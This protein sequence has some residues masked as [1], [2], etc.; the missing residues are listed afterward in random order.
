[1]KPIIVISVILLGLLSSASV[2]SVANVSGAVLT[3]WTHTYG[4]PSNDWAECVIRTSDGGYALAGCTT[5]YGAGS[6]DA[7][8]VKI[9]ASGNSLWNKTYGG[10]DADFWTCV[11]QTNDGGYALGGY[12]A[13]FGLTKYQFWLLKTDS[14]G[15]EQW[16]QKYGGGDVDLANSMI[17]TSDGGYA[18]AGYRFAG[19]N[20]VQLLKTDSAGN[21]EWIRQYFVGGNHDAAYSVIQTSD[22]GY[23]MAGGT[24]PVGVEEGQAFLIKTDS[25][26]NMEWSGTYGG[27][28]EDRGYSVIQTG[29]GGCMLAG[30]TSSYAANGRDVWIVKTNSTGNMLWN[31]TYG[32]ADV[33]RGYSV[34]QTSDGGYALAGYTTSFGAGGTDVYL[35]KT[36]ESGVVPEFPSMLLLPVLV[37]L[38]AV[39]AVLSRK[40]P[41]STIKR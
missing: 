5:S 36:D 34:V 28:S 7:W 39:V 30:Y 21:Q 40:R 2:I 9:D 19:T 38:T 27:V 20:D 22:G 31:Q 12:T 24:N 3:M 4:G 6:W 29:D 17:Q 18:L 15:I 1:M 32:G 23:M 37:L 33:D 41:L 11:I 25:A 14:A 26:G 10:S 8:L 35:V 16:N 13:S